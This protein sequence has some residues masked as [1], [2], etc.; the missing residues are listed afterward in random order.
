MG[1]LKTVKWRFRLPPELAQQQVAEAMRSLDIDVREHAGWLVGKSARSLRRNR[2]AAKVR[3]E[4]RPADPGATAVATV[5][6]LGNAHGAILDE[7][8]K[9]VGDDVTTDDHRDRSFNQTKRGAQREPR[10]LRMGPIEVTDR[11]VKTPSGGGPLAGARARVDSAGDIDRRI[12]ATRLIL[13]GPLAFGL[14]KKKDSRELYLLI[15]G[16][17][18]AHVEEV[19]PKKRKEALTFVAEFNNR[20]RAA[21]SATEGLE[22][23]EDEAQARAADLLEGSAVELTADPT[24]QLQRLAGLRDSGAISDDEFAEAKRR[25]LDSI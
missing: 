12:T 20:A 7:I 10:M 17:G 14:R 5:D 18:F 15:E 23:R 25:I 11:R 8:A 4:F 16:D 19:N 22:L 6:M 13:T 2:G 1:E 21:T 9:A 24:K 3:F